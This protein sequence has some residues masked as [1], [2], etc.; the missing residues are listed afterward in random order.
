MTELDQQ[1]EQIINE[2]DIDGVRALLAK[3]ANLNA[4]LEDGETVFTQVVF[5]R[6][7][8]DY[9]HMLID[10]GASPD[11]PPCAGAT[12]LVLAIYQ[13]DYLLV[14]LLLEHGANPNTPSYGDE[15][16]QTALDA[17]DGD[18]C[19]QETTSDRMN[20]DAIR[21]LLLEYGAVHYRDMASGRVGSEP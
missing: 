4:L 7:D 13:N 18:Y 10:L 8:R 21:Q 6:R 3:G 20:L 2:G 1:L 12:P 9:I 5:C 11:V 14:R 15:E 16:P 19:V 17:L